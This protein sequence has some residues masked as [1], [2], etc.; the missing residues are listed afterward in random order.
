MRF[1]GKQ[2]RNKIFVHSFHWHVQIAMIPCRF[3]E[4]LPF[5]SVI[6]TLPFHLFP[7]TSLTS[8][9]TSSYH[10]FLGLPLSLVAS[11]FIYNT[12]F[13][14]F[15]FLQLYTCPNQCNLFN[16]I[17]SVIVGFLYHCINFFIG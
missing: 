7:P 6:Y 13:W 5:L 8:S 15:Y 2:K 4:L 3:Q 16:H 14:E 1:H 10:L 17:F 11:R 12:F 9:L